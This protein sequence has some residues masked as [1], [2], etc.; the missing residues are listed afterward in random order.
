[1]F[2]I[3]ALHALLVWRRKPRSRAQML[4]QLAES[5]ILGVVSAAVAVGRVYLGYHNFSQACSTSSL[6]IYNLGAL[7]GLLR[8][9]HVQHVTFGTDTSAPH[10]V[11]V[12]LYIYMGA[13]GSRSGC[14]MW[15]CGGMVWS[16]GVAGAALVWESC[17][18]AA[19][20]YYA[21]QRHVP[22]GTRCS[23]LGAQTDTLY[24]AAVS[25]FMK[26]IISQWLRGYMLTGIS[27]R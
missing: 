15:I 12:W 18:M 19:V 20:R 9:F 1:M 26:V 22:P 17:A 5:T 2:F 23:L 6:E 8:Y 3:W 24:Q 21:H 27:A 10:S 7:P 25:V 11:E 13:G 4:F 16:D 14:W